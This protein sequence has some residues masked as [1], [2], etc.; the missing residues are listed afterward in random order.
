M[1]FLPKTLFLFT[2]ILTT[3]PKVQARRDGIAVSMPCFLAREKGPWQSAPALLPAL[4]NKKQG[5]RHP[6]KATDGGPG[7]DFVFFLQQAKITGERR[8]TGHKRNHTP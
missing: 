3:A 6:P 8:E 2:H 7:R 1:A 4:R 5:G